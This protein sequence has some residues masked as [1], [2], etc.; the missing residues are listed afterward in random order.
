[1][2]IDGKALA[3]AIISSLTTKVTALKE[4][5]IVP[6]LAVILVGDDPESIAYIHQKQ[7]T[8]EKIG[9]RFIF[10]QLPKTTTRKELS[11]RID[12]YN[13]D[14]AVHGLIVQRP[15]PMA[16][17][18]TAILHTVLPAKD[19]DGFVPNSPFDVPIAKAVVDILEYI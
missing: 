10:E 16:Q 11:A 5:G 17:D 15:V 4:Q 14:P 7:K 9:G 3:E 19:V 18:T 1:M 6:T 13:A 2:Q 8:T 12:M